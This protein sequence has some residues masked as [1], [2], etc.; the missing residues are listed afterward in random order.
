MQSEL[1]SETEKSSRH[2]TNCSRNNTSTRGGPRTPHWKLKDP[3]GRLIAGRPRPSISAD[4]V[5]IADHCF[6]NF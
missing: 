4:Y 1:V 5:R 3:P 6:I 2:A